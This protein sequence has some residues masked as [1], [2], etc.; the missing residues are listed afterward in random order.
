MEEDAG[1]QRPFHTRVSGD[2]SITT[3]QLPDQNK[4]TWPYLG[5]REAA[6]GGLILGGHVPLSQEFW[7]VVKGQA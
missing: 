5:A 7:E 2:S 6:T 4:V 3:S 1:G